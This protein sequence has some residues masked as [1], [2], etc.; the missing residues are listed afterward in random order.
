MGAYR[1]SGEHSN[2]NPVGHVW[3]WNPVDDS[4]EDFYVGGVISP[5]IVAADG[6][7]WMVCNVFPVGP[8]GQRH[9]RVGLWN[10]ADGVGYPA[11]PA[12]ALRPVGT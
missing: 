3:L 1:G 12:F 5:K 11:P 10:P 7:T 8:D 6:V 2:E 9:A 4:Y